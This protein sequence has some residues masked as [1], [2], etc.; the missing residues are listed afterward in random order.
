MEIFRDYLQHHIGFQCYRFC[1]ISGKQPEA[2][3]FFSNA[4]MHFF[5]RPFHNFP[6]CTSTVKFCKSYS[7]YGVNF[8]CSRLLNIRQAKIRTIEKIVIYV[9]LYKISS[10]KININTTHSVACETNTKVFFFGSRRQRT[11]KPEHFRELVR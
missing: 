6:T 2:H 7:I 1:I 4:D 5:L 8:R 3:L 10:Q 9:H 11:F